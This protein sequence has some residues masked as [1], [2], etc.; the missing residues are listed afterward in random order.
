MKIVL[1]LSG[2][3]DSTVLLLKGLH[4]GHEMYC[5][6]VW[7]S[8]LHEK[9]EKKAVRLLWEQYK[10]AWKQVK[11]ELP[12]LSN[13][14]VN[15]HHTMIDASSSIIPMRNTLLLSLAAA[16]AHGI[17]AQKIWL[18][19]NQEDQCNYADCRPAFCHA[20]NQ[21]LR[22]AMDWNY[23]PE[24]EMPLVDLTKAQIVQLGQEFGIDWSLTWSCYIP[25]NEQPCQT[26]P[27]CLLRQKT[28]SLIGETDSLLK[29]NK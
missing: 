19:A 16:W 22:T 7:Y 15:K 12:E 17:I 28:F 9:M 18:G 8:G 11:L 1:L 3:I 6:S 4:V 24:I 26:C 2:G 5:L 14:L 10:F 27:A 29:D 23:P 21:M 20:Y 25:K 13:A